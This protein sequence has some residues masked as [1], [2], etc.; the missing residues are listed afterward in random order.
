MYRGRECEKVR[1]IQGMPTVRMAM[2]HLRRN[3]PHPNWALLT[4]DS[5][6]KILSS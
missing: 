3:K 1:C 6:G 2:K 5:T 4:P